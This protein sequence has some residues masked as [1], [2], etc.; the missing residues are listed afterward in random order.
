MSYNNN[1]VTMIDDLP[2]LESLDYPAPLSGGN[3]RDTIKGPREQFMPGILPDDAGQYQKFIRPPHTTPIEAGM[4]PYNPPTQ[5]HYN[6]QD[7]TQFVHDNTINMYP[8]CIDFSNHMTAC[9]ICSKFYKNDNTLY[10]I[11]IIV[12]S[13]VCILLLKRVLEV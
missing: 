9:P 4:M 3:V 6:P 13:I 5:Q 2:E 12:L 10:I 8:T 11:A 7:N 1:Y